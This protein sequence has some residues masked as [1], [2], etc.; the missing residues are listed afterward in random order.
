[1]KLW[2]ATG[3]YT[4]ALM[5]VPVLERGGLVYGALYKLSMKPSE[6]GHVSTVEYG[7]HVVSMENGMT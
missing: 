7:P 3:H 4:L 1:V 6:V 5:N 2:L